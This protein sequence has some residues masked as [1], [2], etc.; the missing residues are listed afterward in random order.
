[1]KYCEVYWV[2][3]LRGLEDYPQKT[4]IEICE[5]LENQKIFVV[6]PTKKELITSKYMLIKY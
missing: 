5:N 2:G 1:M 3:M 4:Q 6:V